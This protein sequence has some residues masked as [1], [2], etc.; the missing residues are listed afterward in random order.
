MTEPSDDTNKPQKSL[1]N[2]N[3]FNRL[4]QAQQDIALQTDI[5]P[6]LRK[7]IDTIITNDAIETAK[8]KLINDYS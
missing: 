3:L 4:R 7:L 2:D 5:M 6:T 1:L 8:C